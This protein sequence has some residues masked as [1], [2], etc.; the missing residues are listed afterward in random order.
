LYGWLV[1]SAHDRN[2]SWCSY[3][4]QSAWSLCLLLWLFVAS[5]LVVKDCQHH[6]LHDQGYYTYYLLTRNRM[7]LTVVT[8]VFFCTSI[9]IA[10]F[11]N[12]I[13]M[14]ATIISCCQNHLMHY[15]C[16]LEYRID[17]KANNII[18][19]IRA[20]IFSSIRYSK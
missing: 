6:Y 4:S 1:G 2:H 17:E 20:S 19:I 9:I 8:V 15:H 18:L 16:Y 11:T 10:I 13:T 12:V 3:K 5:M 7:I 14:I